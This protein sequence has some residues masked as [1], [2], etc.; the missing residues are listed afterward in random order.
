[1]GQALLRRDRFWILFGILGVTAIG[2]ALYRRAWSSPRMV[3][4]LPVPGMHHGAHGAD[5]PFPLL[6]A[7]WVVMMVAMMLPTASPMI[8]TYASL[9]RRQ[10]AGAVSRRAFLFRL[11]C[12]VI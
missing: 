7:M 9:A 4:G 8:L 6:L 10:K 1:M 11:L 12:W 2:L 3:P 5:S